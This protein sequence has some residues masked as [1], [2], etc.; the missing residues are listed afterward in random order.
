M[1]THILLTRNAPEEDLARVRAVSADLI[2]EKAPT[3]EGA[4]A[5]ALE[6][7]IIFAGRW[8]DELW[9][10]APKLRWVQSG[11]AGVERFLTP[12]FIASSVILTNAAGVY[13]IPI[14]EHVLGFMLHF[15]RAFHGAL[16]HQLRREWEYPEIGEL[17]G[18]TLGIIGLGGIGVE[19]AKR[20]KSFG[21][22]VIAI[23]RRPDR[24]SPFADEVRGADALPWL[25]AESDYVALCAALTAKTRHLIGE[26]ELRLMKPTAYLINVGRGALVDEP[27]LISALT[28]G[29]IAGAGLDVFAKEPLAAESPLW[30]LPNV[31]ITPHNAGDSPRSHER[32]MELFCEN[33]R[34]Y[35]VGEDLL[36]VVDK[37]EGY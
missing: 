3:M 11:G 16:R 7:E 20:A 10:A 34:R 35:L 12:E 17:S 9:K 37:G 29:R 24:P 33:L 23:R 13:A 36:N 28:E 18:S 2:V 6:A 19:V 21:M 25:L 14:A 8:S 15:A 22:R 32:L 1:P 26:A 31:L 4:L 27:A 30:T 5:R